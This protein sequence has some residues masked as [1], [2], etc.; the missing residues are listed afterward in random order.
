MLNSV[1]IRQ[2][3][4][5]LGD[6][7][8]V[9]SWV[10]AA[11]PSGLYP[12]FVVLEGDSVTDEEWQ[13]VADL[14][15]LALYTEN[16]LIRIEANNPGEFGGIGAVATDKLIITTAVA[17]WLDTY[18]TDQVFVVTYVDPAGDYLLVTDTKPFPTAKASL[19]WELWDSTQTV[20][21]GAQ[22][23]ASTRRE[24]AV[25]TTFLR[26]HWTQLF[27]TVKKASSRVISNEAF[28]EALVSASKIHGAVFE[29]ID[30]ETFTE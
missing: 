2:E 25:A 23:G 29:G 12:L 26:R 8:R 24:D 27:A 17:E 28:V 18:V 21:R 11:D 16:R 3:K 14:D 22:A 30:T 15:D 20:L 1:T 19:A 6:E 4:T 5:I 7:F 9:V 10:T 13:R